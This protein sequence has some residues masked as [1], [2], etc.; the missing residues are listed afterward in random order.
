MRVEDGESGR[1]TMAKTHNAQAGE[2]GRCGGGNGESL[3]HAAAGFTGK[4]A[5]KKASF[6]VALDP[7]APTYP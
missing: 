1:K 6:F 7:L 5:L 2:L 4:Q 3:S